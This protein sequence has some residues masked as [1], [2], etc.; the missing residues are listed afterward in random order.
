MGYSKIKV[1]ILSFSLITSHPIAAVALEFC[2]LLSTV[3]GT[4]VLLYSDVYNRS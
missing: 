3:S 1:T 2:P 4:V